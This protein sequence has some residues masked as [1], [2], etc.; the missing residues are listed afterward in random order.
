MHVKKMTGKPG[1]LSVNLMD[2][3]KEIHIVPDVKPMHSTSGAT[4]PQCM[5][6]VERLPLGTLIRHHK[7]LLS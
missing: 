1:W 6:T 7:T 4:C 3:M 5:P 2:E